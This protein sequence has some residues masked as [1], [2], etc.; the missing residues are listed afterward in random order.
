LRKVADVEQ[1]SVY[2]N[3]DADSLPATVVER[4]RDGT[5]DW[6]TVTSSAIAASLYSLLPETAMS[7]IG[8]ETRLASLSPVTS[9]TLD[10]LRWNAAVEASVHNWNGLV[11][12]LVD[13]V[14]S[15]RSY[16][17]RQI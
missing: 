11:R 13:R 9:A 16:G 6:I 1:V 5:V 12:A 17:N 4:I 2:R 14:Q 8:R 10:R 15:E 7:R 3:L